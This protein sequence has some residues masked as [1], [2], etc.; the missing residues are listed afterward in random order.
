MTKKIEFP[1]WKNKGLSAEERNNLL[2]GACRRVFSSED[3]KIALNMLLSDLFVYETTHTK[4]EQALNEY[5][6]FFIRERMGVRDTKALTDFI[7]ETAAFGGG[8]ECRT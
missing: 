2:V 6:K 7:A 4:R 8:K 5:G 1:F 3:G